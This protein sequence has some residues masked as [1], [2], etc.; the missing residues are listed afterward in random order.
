MSEHIQLT[1]AEMEVCRRI[2]E[3]RW[4]DSKRGGFNN[5][6]TADDW[7]AADDAV[8]CAGEVAFARYLGIE[9]F[10]PSV[11]RFKDD[12]PDVLD[13]EV[14][15]ASRAGYRLIIRPKDKPFRIYIHTVHL[16]GGAVQIIGWLRGW[17]ARVERWWKQPG[18][19]PGAWFV[20]DTE[21]NPLHA[22]PHRA[23]RHLWNCL[24][25]DEGARI[26]ADSLNGQTADGGVLSGEES[27]P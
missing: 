6:Y 18:S 1:E 8:G 22:L 7:S 2:G 15:T 21:L 9:D 10:I 5:E 4:T 13:Y 19:R 14:R 24:Y 12:Q 25:D 26:T 17:A 3:K 23:G 27:V 16:G 20:P 11:N